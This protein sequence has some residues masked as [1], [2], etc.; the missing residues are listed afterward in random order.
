MG[1]YYTVYNEN[2]E[3]IIAF[4]NASR[5]TEILG[6]K[7]E[8]Q[9]HAFVSKTRSGLRKKYKVV[10]EDDTSPTDDDE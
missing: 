9:F 7:N 5:C 6:L 4:G 8:R 1:K 10:V 2:T 3:E